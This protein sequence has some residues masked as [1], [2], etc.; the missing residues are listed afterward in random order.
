MKKLYVLV[1]SLALLIFSFTQISQ[2][3]QAAVEVVSK[4]E[5][6]PE[7][8]KT[9][10]LFLVCNPQWLTP[11]KSAGLYALFKSFKNFGRTIGDDNAAVWFWKARS[12][13]TDSALAEN[14]DVERSVRFCQAWNLKPSEGP[15]L[16][17]TT[18]YPDESSLSSGL[19]KGNAV[20]SLGNMSPV[21]ISGL[22]TKLND[23]LVE[24]RK[25]DIPQPVV[26]APLALWVRLLDVTQRTINTFGCAWTFKIDAGPLNADLQACNTK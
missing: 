16:V 24:K 9:Y 15:H 13:V 25:V 11:E 14:L 26:V 18:I 4:S 17:I 22:L 7:N 8:F 2:S 5:K 6:I 21:E 20:Y 12:P 1:P 10:S 19:P 3:W 23:E